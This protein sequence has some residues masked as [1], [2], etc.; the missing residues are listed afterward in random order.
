MTVP[1][2]RNRG[3]ALEL[4]LEVRVGRGP[5]RGEKAP[6]LEISRWVLELVPELAETQEGPVVVLL[7]VEW[8]VA[9]WLVVVWPV[10]E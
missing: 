1:E 7:V 4:R 6:K 2:R 5:V 8:R 10:V 9:E 3:P